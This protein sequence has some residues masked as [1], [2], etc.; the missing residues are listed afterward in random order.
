MTL[1][2]KY[3]KIIIKEKVIIT[4]QEETKNAEPEKAEEKVEPKT[5]EEKP[6]EQ[7]K[8]EPKE[9][10]KKE[11]KEEA[12]DEPKEEQINKIYTIIKMDNI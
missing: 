6:V 7:P 12:K 5:E 11:Q 10:A 3:Q 8:E 2:L 1:L 4:K 9:E